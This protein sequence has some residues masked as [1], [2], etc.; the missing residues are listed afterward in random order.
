[1]TSPSLSN[2]ASSV[3]PSVYIA[4]QNLIAYVSC[5]SGATVARGKA[6]NTTVAYAPEDLST[7]MSARA[8][9]TECTYITVNY[10]M[11]GDYSSSGNPD[12]FLSIPS[13]LTSLDPAWSTCTPALYGAWDPPT[14]LRPATALTGPA[15]KITPSR[16]AAPAGRSTRVYAPAT[17]TAADDSPTNEAPSVAS[18]PGAPQIPNLPKTSAAKPADPAITQ[19]SYTTADLGSPSNN[20][21]NMPSNK[22]GKPDP[23]DPSNITTSIPSGKDGKP[24]LSDPSNITPSIPS[25]K[26]GK[27]DPSDDPPSTPTPSLPFFNG[28]P[29]AKAPDGGLLFASSTVAPGSQATISGHV[30]S[31]GLSNAVVDGIKYALPTHTAEKAQLFSVTPAHGLVLSPDGNPNE[32]KIGDKIVSVNEPAILISGA[33]VS[34]SPSE[35]YFGSLALP[36]TAATDS[37]SARLGDLIISAFQSGQSPAGNRNTD[38]NA[39]VFTSGT[40]RSPHFHSISVLA[41]TT[42]IVAMV[43]L[44]S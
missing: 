13:T 12:F 43:D 7:A 29:M 27:P 8:Q 42:A 33:A 3:V 28:K 40:L 30:I 20:I 38:S 4:Y 5:P 18:V 10:T 6:Y 41:L 1:M 2:T 21:H 32:V 31:V 9:Q 16:P 15:D 36:L 34:L 14:T 19:K 44:A 22:D 17:T 23:S 24:G 39:I 26:D 25:V 37:S 11:L 35:L